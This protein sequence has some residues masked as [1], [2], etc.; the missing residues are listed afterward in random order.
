MTRFCGK[1]WYLSLAV[2]TDSLGC[3]CVSGEEGMGEGRGKR[4]RGSGTFLSKLQ[5]KS[6]QSGT[7][8]VDGNE[9]QVALDS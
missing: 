8:Q 4:D 7:T 6:F 3:V 9:V 5:A 2:F 1:K